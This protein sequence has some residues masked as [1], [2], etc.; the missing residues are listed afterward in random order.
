L[1]AAAAFRYTPNAN[2]FGSDSFTFR[3]RDGL[4]PSGIGTVSVDVAPV[5]DAP[6]P[7]PFFGSTNEDVPLAGQLVAT[8]VDSDTL[9][10]NLA[11]GPFQGSL[12]LQP[13]GSF[14]YTPGA[15][16]FGEDAFAFTVSDGIVES[17]VVFAVITVA[18][19]NDAPVANDNLYQPVPEDKVFTIPLASLGVLANDIDV[20]GDPLTAI[21]VSS[22]SHGILTFFNGN[23]TFSYTPGANFFGADSFTYQARDASGALS[24]VATVFLNVQNVNDAPVAGNA[25]FST[26]EDVA[27]EALLPATDIDGDALTFENLGGPSHGTLELLGAAAFRY[28]PNANFF[29]SDSFTFRASDGLLP[30]GIGTVS[31]DV[32]PVN[33]APG[34]GTVGDREVDEGSTLSFTATA[35][36]VDVPANPHTFSLGAGAP[37]GAAV[38]ADGFFAWTPSESQGPDSYAITIRVTEDSD[39]TLFDE[40]TFTVTVNEVNVAPV[41]DPIGSKTVDEGD[42]LSFTATATDADLPANVLTF[43]LVGAPAGAS[44]HPTTGVFTWTPTETQGPADYTFDVLVTDN[45]TPALSESETFTITVNEVNQAPVLTAIGAKA[46]SEGEVLAFTATATDADLPANTLTFSL[47]PGAPAG[48]TLTPAGA[49]TWAPTEEQGPGSFPVTIRVTDNGTPALSDFETFTITVSEDANID[50]GAQASDG[51]PD[52]FRL[53]RNGDNVQVELNGSLVFSRA[54]AGSPLLTVQGS[55]DDDTLIV[56]FTG[57]NPIP[58]SGI[59]YN[60]GGPGD[61]D[62]LTLTGPAPS[63]ITYT[64]FDGSSGTVDVAGSLITYAGLEPITVGA[65]VAD[66]IFVFGP[67]NDTISLMIGETESTLSSPSSETVTFLNPTGSV[68][69]QAGTGNDTITVVSADPDPDFDLFIDGGPGQNT[70]QAPAGLASGLVTGTAGNDTITVNQS[71]GTVTVSVNGVTSTLEGLSGLQVNS[72]GGDDNITLKGLKFGSQVD[73]GEGNDRADATQVTAAAVTLFGGAGNDSLYG[74]S[75]ADVLDGGLGADSI[76]GGAG[77]DTIVGGDGNDSLWGGSGND[78]IEGGTGRDKLYGEAGNDTLTGGT[79]NDSLWGGDGDDLLYGSEGDDY[80]RGESGRDT[81]FG[82][83]G[84]DDLNGGS[85]QDTLDWGG[86]VSGNGSAYRSA[87]AKGWSVKSWLRRFLLEVGQDDP[88]LGIQVTIPC[89]EHEL[90][91]KLDHSPSWHGRR[92]RQGHRA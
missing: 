66:H 51:T 76:R 31:V 89:R 36:D 46:V 23:G 41:L 24:N 79:G 12:D 18:P 85:G 42:T 16:F 87:A 83:P 48:A 61:S 13:G 84:D 7:Q 44:I 47:D 67:G 6:V 19:V 56:D 2:F 92:D 82:G 65:V 86:P 27:L 70:I 29:G 63:P 50:G 74:G 4:L 62:G 5:N 77:N 59:Q 54:V 34:L 15:N 32:A 55:T 9:T 22:T 28:T 35:T 3:A 91:A 14:V 30:S 90:V 37:E 39:P 17:D 40:E 1:L 11:F 21:L 75:W 49:F 80:L 72:L 57:G 25:A 53:F 81:L 60:G 73:A 69:V 26:D 20:D 64:F 88:N 10:F 52:T 33:D 8:D 45:G 38:T 58:T 68:T 71:N 78:W 43:S